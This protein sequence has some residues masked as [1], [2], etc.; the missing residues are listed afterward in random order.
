MSMDPSIPNSGKQTFPLST[1][2]Y[3]FINI[4]SYFLK[5]YVLRCQFVHVSLEGMMSMDSSIKSRR[6]ISFKLTDI[7][8]Y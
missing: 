8:A 4:R 7:S 1:L 6:H 2:L 5:F 3:S